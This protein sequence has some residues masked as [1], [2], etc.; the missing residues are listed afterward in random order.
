MALH[1]PNCEICARFSDIEQGKHPGFIS[2][3]PTGFFVLGDSQQWRGY[4]L[5]LCKTPVADLEELDWPVR[6]QFLRDVALCSQ[7]VADVA[8]P[9]KMNVE[10]LGNVVPHLHFHFFPRYLTEPE[11]LQ[12]VWGQMN[13]TEETALD[14]E[15]DGELMEQLR[16][17]I[18]RLRATRL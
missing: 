2:E 4:C 16:R 12:P 13:P 11:P 9:H 3:L 17:E 6:L 1:H 5:L 8:R 10:S 15:T 7:A 18:E 14:E